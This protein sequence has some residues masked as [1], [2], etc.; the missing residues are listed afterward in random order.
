MIDVWI[1]D[2]VVLHLGQ[3]GRENRELVR[4]AKAANQRHT[5]LHLTSGPSPHAVLCSTTPTRQQLLAAAAQVK[6]H[7][8]CRTARRASVD[9][10]SL[11]HV[12]VTTGA[13]GTVELKRTPR[14]LVV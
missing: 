14:T 3:D 11:Q 4:T 13:V 1:D 7:S 2:T 6:A 9:Y 10:I 5:W 12:Q 8:R